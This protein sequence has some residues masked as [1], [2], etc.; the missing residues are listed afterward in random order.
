[1]KVILSRKGF[2][3]AAGGC[4]SLII[5]NKYISIPI[6][7]D[8]TDLKYKDVNICGY[9]I[10]TLFD[11][12]D[13][14]GKHKIEPAL[15]KNVNDKK[16]KLK[17]DTCHLDP[18]I[19]KGVFGQCDD[20]G[21]N[22]ATHLKNQGIGQGDLFLFF[23]WFRK[24]DLEQ[25]H[26][27]GRDMH[28]IYAYL[29][30]GKVF[31]LNNAAD[32]KEA[33][34]LYPEHPHIKYM[35]K[36]NTNPKNPHFLFA[37]NINDELI[38]GSGIPSCGRLNLIVEKDEET[39]DN[40]STVLT[41]PGMSRSNWKLPMIFYNCGMTYHTDTPTEHWFKL[42]N[43]FCQLKSVSRGQEFVI[44]KNDEINGQPDKFQN[45]EIIKWALNLIKKNIVKP[46]Q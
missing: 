4:S 42:D 19:E 27:T 30:V 18:N 41:M 32:V 35:S 5:D 29:K 15:E 24:Y 7:D 39:I 16:I 8:K 12:Y 21:S 1:M 26:F 37:A 22:A 38:S 6:P 17:I 3:K 40:P 34:K 43:N 9:N 14:R 23:G 44:P 13:Y 31:D 33:Q 20:N 45:D 25:H 11:N 10:Q 28:C 36:Y 2:D 46:K